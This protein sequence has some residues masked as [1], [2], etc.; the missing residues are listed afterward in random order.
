MNIEK[1]REYAVEI[2]REIS[3][4]IEVYS[5]KKSFAEGIGLIGINGDSVY[6]HIQM[7]CDGELYGSH[8][9]NSMRGKQS[10]RN[11]YKLAQILKKLNVQ[12]EDPIIQKIK[13]VDGRFV[14]P[15][16]K[17]EGKKIEEEIRSGKLRSSLE[18]R[19][20]RF[21]YEKLKEV[22]ELIEKLDNK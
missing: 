16:S 14:Y 13:E 7:V 10:E 4:R 22:S 12:E 21:S 20:G 9:E 5:T 1:Y 18:R 11:L 3:A 15:P 17:N 2:G 19:L 6:R 8:M